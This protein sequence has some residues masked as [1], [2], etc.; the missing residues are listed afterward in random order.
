MKKAKVLD[1]FGR[2]DKSV[3]PVIA[4]ASALGISRQAVYQWPEDVPRSSQALI[5]LKS[6]GKLKMDAK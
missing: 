4:T 6:G 2:I 3:N 5:E 1:F